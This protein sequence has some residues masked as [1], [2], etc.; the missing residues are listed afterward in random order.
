MN[1]RTDMA[2]EAKRLWDCAP[3]RKTKLKGVRAYRATSHGIPADVVEI[4]HEEGARELGKPI[5]TYITVELSSAF[6]REQNGFRNTC[7]AISDFLSEMLGD[8]KNLL[9]AGL[10]N[11]HITPDRVGPCAIEHLLVTR[12]LKVAGE[13]MFQTYPAVSSAIPGVMGRTG[14]ESA[15]V[16]RSLAESIGADGVVVIDAL[17]SCEPERLCRS[18]QICNTGLAPGSGV[19]NHRMAFS[20]ESMGVPVISL[21]VPTV[22]DGETFQ[23]LQHVPEEHL[24]KGLLLS[25][26]DIDAKVL[27]LGRLI[28]YAIDLAI[29]PSLSLEDI[30]ALIG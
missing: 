9:I 30:P 6:H 13:P 16:V 17:A 10:G 12:H 24:C 11:A 26:D 4:L 23:R 25:T 3:E 8:K 5:G 19:G 22:V 20:Q 18:V 2:I 21:G 14:M 15:A 1:L 27:E 7:A 28:G 29:F